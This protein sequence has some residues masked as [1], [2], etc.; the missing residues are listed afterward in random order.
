MTGYVSPPSDG[1]E[2]DA[3]LAF[4][5]QELVTAMNEFARTAPVP[6]FD[7]AG[8]KSRTRR[9]RAGFVAA[10]AA[11]LIAAGGGTALATV[12]TGSHTARP[13]ATTTTPAKGNV[14]TVPYVK[15][16]DIGGMDLADATQALGQAGLKPGTITHAAVDNCKPGSVIAVSPLAPAV[17]HAGDHVDLTLCG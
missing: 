17:V 14:T 6:H 2:G 12:G 8:I 16:F 5:E 13:A 3:H 4:F 11:V 9:R 7:A 10:A 15:P 1:R